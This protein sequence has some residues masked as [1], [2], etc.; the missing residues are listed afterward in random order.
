MNKQGLPGKAEYLN[1]D[2]SPVI[3][4]GHNLTSEFTYNDYEGQIPFLPDE[5][6]TIQH[7]IKN[8]TSDINYK[9]HI[10]DYNDMSLIGMCEMTVLYDILTQLT[11]PN[12]FIQEQQKKLL[13]DL[14]T[15]RKLFNTVI[16]TGDIFLNIYAEIYLISKSSFEHK[17]HN[18]YRKTL[19]QQRPECFIK[20]NFGGCNYESL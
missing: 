18:K 9:V 11:P 6:K 12:G 20:Y 19:Y 8:V 2:M 1:E 16:N 14:K 10:L 7:Q 17:N 13:I 4:K 5:S 3:N 15:K